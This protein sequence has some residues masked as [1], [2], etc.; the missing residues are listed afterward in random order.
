METTPKEWVDAAPVITPTDPLSK[1]R[2]NID[3]AT[4]TLSLP[5]VAASQ[6]STPGVPMTPR[7]AHGTF[8]PLVCVVDFHHARGP[9]VEKWF[10][11]HNGFDPATEYDW[12]LLPFQALSDGAHAST[13][14]FSYFTLLKPAQE[15]GTPATS[16][17]GIAC[18]RQL[19]AAKLI[20][21]PSDVT[22]STVQKAVVIIADSPQTF[23]MLRQRLSIVTCRWFEQRE[24]TNVEILEGLQESLA[25]DYKKGLMNDEVDRDQYLGMSLRELVR[26]FREKTLVLLKCCLLQHKML[27]FGSRCEKLCMIQFSLIS[28]I[29]GLLRNLQ[30]CAGPE[31]DSYSKN[32]KRA[33]SLKTSDRGSLLA[34]LGMPFQIFG[35]GSLFGPY[36][37]LQQLDILADHQTKSY[38]VGST[39]SLLLQ[40]KERYSDILINLDDNSVQII[41]PA[42]HRALALTTPD[43][44]WID[45]ITQEVNET[46][47]EANPEHPKDMGYAGSEEFIRLQFEEYLLNMASATKYHNFLK[48][49]A[50]NP[51]I[52]LAH[53]E[54]DPSSD[55]GPEWF[56]AWEK[57]ENYKI[58]DRNT[59]SHIFDVNDPRHPCAGGLTIDDVQR[60]LA[61]QIQDLHLDERFAVGREVLGRNFA[62]GRERASIL[63]N[64]LYAD[65]EVMR[66]AQRKKA[67]ENRILHS[68]AGTATATQGPLSPT[69]GISGVDFSKAQQTMQS[70]GAKAS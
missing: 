66:E 46:W 2:E 33:T 37:P 20:N 42:L 17:F 52:Q 41:N 26:Q 11:I 56:E 65:M 57:T 25:D 5:A 50:N 35:K 10:G 29:P 69:N 47:N 51:R 3:T 36:T 55:F 32:L 30:D 61:Q 14:D 49:H 70:V 68:Q 9:E 40:Q 7:S 8:P 27:F 34:Y 58:W 38:I 67:D 24:F 22:R 23:G 21:R 39:N 48:K 16:L 53:I 59:D 31:L 45:F 13:E 18:T 44:R 62:A 28:L 15:D 54:G 64:K 43:R 4:T 12:S 6:P 63:F 60:R 19:D 1:P